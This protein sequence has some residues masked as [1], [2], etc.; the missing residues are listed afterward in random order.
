MQL[1]NIEQLI[2]VA[3]K[4]NFSIFEIPSEY[5][6]ADIMPNAYHM[7]AEDDKASITIEQ[8]RELN[9]IVNAKQSSDLYIVVE[10]PEKTNEKA[11]N[12]FLKTLEE[13]RDLVHFIFLTRNS[14]ALLPTILSRAHCFR[15]I[16]NNHINDAPNIDPEILNLAKTYISLTPGSQ[17][18]SF[19]DKIAK[20][21]PSPRAR[22]KALAMLDAAIILLYKSYFKTNNPA[23]L[24]KLEALLST[25]EAIR[26]NGNIKLQLVAG[27][28]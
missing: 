13:P 15:I 2:S 14:S 20:T 7:R 25:E 21:K 3:A 24:K 10:E 19:A 16:D 4:T 23:F 18:V 12:A 5:N 9:N 8:F 26:Q 28:L 22:Q 17:L 27:V 1:N 6:F 11:I